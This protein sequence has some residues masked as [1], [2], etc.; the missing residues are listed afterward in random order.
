[1]GRRLKRQTLGVFLNGMRVGDLTRMP[2]TDLSFQYDANWLLRKDA[3]A[4][5]LSLPLREDTWRGPNV[6]A[7]FD[8]L[9]PDNDLFRRRLAEKTR[10]DGTGPFELLARIGRDCVG[11]LQFLQDDEETANSTTLETTPLSDMDIGEIL[12]TLKTS[13]LGLRPETGFRISLA[14]A[15][16][17]TALLRIGGKWHEPHGNTPT[18]H[19]LKPAIGR[20]PNGIDLRTSTVNEWLCLHLASFFG[21]DVARAELADFDGVSCL[22]VERFDRKWDA[23]GQRL[24]RIP[25]EDLC[26]ALGVSPTRK[27]ETE[28]G[29]SIRLIME[30][31]NGS[32]ARDQDRASFLRAQLV[33]Y[34]L[35]A[36][37]GHAKNFSVFLRPVGFCLTP[38]YDIMSVHPALA[39]RQL[40]IKEASLAMAVGT[41]RHYRLA[42][43]QRRHWEQ[44][45]KAVGLPQEEL[46]EI[47]T[48]L[49]HRTDALPDFARK[50]DGQVPPGILDPVLA[51]IAKGMRVLL[52]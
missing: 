1:M 39:S 46:A 28:G 25:Q 14:G 16:E 52:G 36:I 40:Q 15:Q 8:N 13:P 41:R 17:K 35:A 32:D 2:G 33:F 23:T 19:I 5:S 9:L 3:L 31:L 45:A 22:V 26:Q 51:G 7:F 21:L 29:P 47:L 48:D 50:V 4:I 12:R 11:A 20:L 10:A 43:I 44:T 34:L 49:G 24:H 27:Y 30:F 38:L 18:S 42:E 37:D 6:Y